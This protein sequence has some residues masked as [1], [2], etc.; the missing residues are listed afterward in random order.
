MLIASVPVARVMGPKV[1]GH[2]IY[3]LFLTGTAQRLANFG[4]P[5]TCCKYMAEF[6]GR[7]QYGIAHE[8]F[9]VTFRYQATISGIITSLGLCLV[10]FSE[11]EY[12]LIAALIVAS[13]WPAMISYI[14]AQANVAAENLRANL[15]ASIVYLITYTALVILSLALHWG[16]VGLAIATLVSRVLEA[17]LRYFGVQRWLRSY[18]RAALPPQLRNRMF[19]F[20]RHNLVLLA[21]GLVVW[22][23]S[24]VLF[25]KQLS[26]V[27]QV[28]FYSLAFSIANQLLMVPRALSNAIGITILAQYGRDPLRLGALV[29][30]ATRY[31]SVLAIPLFLGTAAIAEPL[32]RSTYGGGYV[33]VVPVL[34]IICISSIPRAFQL[35]TEYLLQATEKQRFMVKWLAVTA[36]VN[37]SL[38]ALIIPNHGAL[39]AAIANGL[40]QTM[41][42]AGLFWKADGAYSMRSQIRFL[43]ALCVSGA[44]MVGAVLV[45]VRAL[46][47]WLGLVA[48]VAIGAVIFFVCLRTTRSLEAEDWGRLHQWTQPL[49]RPIHRIML[50][51]LA[52]QFGPDSSPAPVVAAQSSNQ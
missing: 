28:A 18:P 48:G 45:V 36:L 13:M 44:V 19:N 29:R 26:D 41:G 12:R 21:L 30:N 33:A 38:D 16:L 46:P 14:P 34:W 22:D 47:P 24:E 52:L 25:L 42:V 8:V 23:R 1:L 3:L 9:R 49:P 4:I 31:V 5:A 10:A 37:V 50:R 40:A 6:L 32:I 39:G 11:P 43:G 15:P 35:H 20:S 51:L 17:G 7:Q 27:Q 2:Y